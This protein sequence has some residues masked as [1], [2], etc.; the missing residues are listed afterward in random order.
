MTA[1]SSDVYEQIRA[2]A[3]RSAA[4]VAPL[5]V[6]HACSHRGPWRDS[7]QVLDVGCG[8]GWWSAA[9]ADDPRVAEV[10][11]FDA[12]QP[13]IVAPGVTVQRLDLE[14]GPLKLV[15]EP[16]GLVVC[17]EVA[18]H[19]SIAAAPVLVKSLCDATA[20]TGV[21]AFS[22]A[23]PGQTGHGHINEQWPDYWDERFRA[24]GW[25]LVDPL[26]D[27]LWSDPDVEPWYAQNLLL[28]IATPVGA[29]PRSP[30]RL[31]HP[32]IWE[33]RVHNTAYWREQATRRRRS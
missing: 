5:L 8:E 11:S 32:T 33:Y 24:C 7:L 10:V 20:P 2:G 27:R 28:G 13:S 23:I 3:Q 29:S 21:I 22:A 17:L 14:R 12:E 4:I 31:V 30:R 9:L 18:E 6:D 1:F 26:R 25:M 19:L 16:F 15:G